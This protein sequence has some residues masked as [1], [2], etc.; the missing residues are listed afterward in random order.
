MMNVISLCNSM[1]FCFMYFN[2]ILIDA[3]K[4]RNVI[5]LGELNF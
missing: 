4:Y 5:F 2:A 1:Y 3:H